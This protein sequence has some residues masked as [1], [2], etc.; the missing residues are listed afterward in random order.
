MGFDG[1][2][3]A[4]LAHPAPGPFESRLEAQRQAPIIDLMV[5][6][7][8]N[9]AGQPGFQVRFAAPGLGPVQPLDFDP[10][11]ALKLVGEAKLLGVVPGRGDHHRAFVAVFRVD[12][13]GL[14]QLAGEVR[15]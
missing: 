4:V 13:A 7:A 11:A 12:A 9:R 1:L 15:P 5:P 8:E 6:G 10:Q 14:G 2:D 3:R